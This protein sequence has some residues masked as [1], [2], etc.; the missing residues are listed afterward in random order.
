MEI[1]ESPELTWKR[2][3]FSQD[4]TNDRIRWPTPEAFTSR[5]KT[6]VVFLGSGA[7]RI[8]MDGKEI[9]FRTD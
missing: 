2:L 4:N 7:A 5:N 8:F 6:V 9:L 3:I 1:S